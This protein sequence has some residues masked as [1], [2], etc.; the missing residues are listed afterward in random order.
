SAADPHAVADSNLIVHIGA[1]S[2]NKLALVECQ[3]PTL[4]AQ[5]RTR[6]SRSGWRRVVVAVSEV[7]ARVVLTLQVEAC[8]QSIGLRRIEAMGESSASSKSSAPE[9]DDGEGQWIV[10]RSPADICRHKDLVT[11]EESIGSQPN[12]NL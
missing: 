10:E 8:R 3:N 1:E 9:I 11:I 2:G 7:A 12:L 6:G 5:D 4:H